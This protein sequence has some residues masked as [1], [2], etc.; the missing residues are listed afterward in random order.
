LIPPDP[1]DASVVS[2]TDIVVD[3]VA[4]VTNQAIYFQYG[5][6]LFGSLI[7]PNSWYKV[8]LYITTE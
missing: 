2:V 4:P 6:S 7:K 1:P 5:V 8:N 3:G